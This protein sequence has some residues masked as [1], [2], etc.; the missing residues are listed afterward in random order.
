[1]TQPS[2]F[3]NSIATLLGVLSSAR[4]QR[5]PSDDQI[6]ADNIEEAFQLTRKLYRDA[7]S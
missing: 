1:M 3:V 7:T 4:A 5:S 6:I 2:D